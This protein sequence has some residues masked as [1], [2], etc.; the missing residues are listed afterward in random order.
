M[1]SSTRQRSVRHSTRAIV[2]A[3]VSDVL[4][5]LVFAAIG[6]D[7]HVR[8]D[9]ISGVFLTAWPFLAGAAFGWL[10][11][12]AW[13]RPLSLPAGVGIWLGAVAGGMALRALTGQVVVLPFVI[14]ALLSLGLF[15][16]GYR[17]LLALVRRLRKR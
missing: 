11:A 4:L 5:I 6:R 13:R 7:A 1:T 10:A 3:A 12:R 9:V 17:A 15:L 14:V 16:V 2:G 8:P